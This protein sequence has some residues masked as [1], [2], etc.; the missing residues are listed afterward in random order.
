MVDRLQKNLETFVIILLVLIGLVAMA[1]ST[2]AVWFI[3]APFKALEA[4]LK[5]A[6]RWEGLLP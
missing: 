1:L 4:G 3:C 6:A 2:T 5:W